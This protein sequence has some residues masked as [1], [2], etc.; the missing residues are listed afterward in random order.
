MSNKTF[1]KIGQKFSGDELVEEVMAFSQN[2]R[3]EDFPNPERAGCPDA[4][5]LRKTVEAA[6][7]PAPELAEHLVHCSNC[8]DDLQKLR[9]KSAAA[10]AR[11][12]KSAGRF[13]WFLLPATAV[14]AA[15]FVMCFFIR[16][17]PPEFAQAVTNVMEVN[18]LPEPPAEPAIETSDEVPVTTNTNGPALRDANGTLPQKP[19]VS[20]RIYNFDLAASQVTR[21]DSEGETP[22]ALPASRVLVRIRL[23]DNSPP[24]RYRLSILDS[25]AEEAVDSQFITSDGKTVAAEFDLTKVRGKLRLC[26]APDGEIPDCVPILVR[27]LK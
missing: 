21:G 9:S 16:Q 22:A 18:K 7:L 2:Y 25:D 5:V 15:V 19:E 17:D 20:R 27:K 6:Q 13:W 26:A 24:G 1:K 12:T 23:I 14:F 4:S 11:S 10:A 8:F 3:A